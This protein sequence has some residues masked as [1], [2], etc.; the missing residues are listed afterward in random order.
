MAWS[1]SSRQTIVADSWGVKRAEVLLVSC[2]HRANRK[3]VCEIQRVQDDAANI[4]VT[5][6]RK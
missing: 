5:V 1:P 3:Q 6:A 2:P 4:A